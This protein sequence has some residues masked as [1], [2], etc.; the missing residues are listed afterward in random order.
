MLC[1]MGIVA[2][3]LRPCYCLRLS[4]HFLS[5]GPAVQMHCVR[6]VLMYYLQIQPNQI[7]VTMNCICKL[8]IFLLLADAWCLD[9]LS[10]VADYYIM[11]VSCVWDECNQCPFIFNLAVYVRPHHHILLFWQ[12]DEAIKDETMMQNVM[13]H[14]IYYI[15]FA[16]NHWDRIR[17]DIVWLP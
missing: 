17:R 4:A 7:S 12:S 13:V 9:V 2:V 15:L 6:V 10:A 8:Y 14:F 11:H 16:S 1:L 3:G 5:Y